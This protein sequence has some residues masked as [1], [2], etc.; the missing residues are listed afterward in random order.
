MS[1]RYV[2]LTLY[3]LCSANLVMLFAEGEHMAA[4]V[5]QDFN[6]WSRSGDSRAGRFRG[7]GRNW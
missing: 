6:D 3:S 7:C 4:K 2:L 5:V 1:I